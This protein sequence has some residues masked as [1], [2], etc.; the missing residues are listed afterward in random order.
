MSHGPIQLKPDLYAYYKEVG[1]REPEPL[2]KLR[3][4]FKDHPQLHMHTAPEIAQFLAFLVRIYR[5]RHI[6]EIGTFIGYSTLS[7]ALSMPKNCKL[8]TCDHDTDLVFQAQEI[9][10]QEGHSKTISFKPGPAQD[11][12]ARLEDLEATADFFYIDA[13]KSGYNRYYETAMRL[14]EPGALI[15]FDN[16][17]AAGQITS[18]DP[19][20]YVRSLQK[21]NKKIHADP[22]VDMLLLSFGDGLTIVQKL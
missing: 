13:D 18:D 16:T 1:Y 14:S 22:R 3:E 19:R 15:L 4:H 20:P 7:M 5:P 10:E 2:R 9:W 11:T 17:L 12:L 8:T 6:I 21:L